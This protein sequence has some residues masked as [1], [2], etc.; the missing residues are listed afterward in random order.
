[1]RGTR[2]E[3]S[4]IGTPKDMLKR[5]IKRDVKMPCKRVIF[6]HRGPAGEP[7][8][9]SLAGTFERKG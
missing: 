2:R 3:G 8:E 9:D 5:F 1:M 6:L 7:G 4:F